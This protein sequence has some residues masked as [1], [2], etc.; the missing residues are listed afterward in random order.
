MDMD[1]EVESGLSD[2]L[3]LSGT[4][5]GTLWIPYV[6]NGTYYFEMDA[7]KLLYILLKDSVL[8]SKCRVYACDVSVSIRICS[9]LWNTELCVPSNGFL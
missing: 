2:L 7:L 3:Y 9:I 6:K 5:S 4:F 8:C 1:T